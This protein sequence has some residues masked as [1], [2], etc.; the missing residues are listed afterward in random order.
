MK[1]REWTEARAKVEAESK[2][3][4]CGLSEGE[5]YVGESGPS[6]CRLEAAHLWP[7]SRGGTQN[8]DGI[9]PLCGDCHRLFDSFR[10]D[11]LAV[12]SSDEQVELVRQS[13]G[14]ELARVR[15]LPSEYPKRSERFQ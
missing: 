3:R 13:G 1:R 4:F 12:L 14:I 2:C 6:F 7:R 10:L 5:Y 15:V 9:V 11:L 8:P